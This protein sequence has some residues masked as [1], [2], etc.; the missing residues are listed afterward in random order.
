[1]QKTFLFVRINNCVLVD[2]KACAF[3]LWQSETI[4]VQRSKVK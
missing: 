2:Q 1:L 4:K 3:W